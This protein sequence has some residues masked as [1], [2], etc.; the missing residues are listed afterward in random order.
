MSTAHGHMRK[1]SP[2]CM[3]NGTL[4]ALPGLCQFPRVCSLAC[5]ALPD[6][7]A[8]NPQLVSLDV[9]GNA[10][11]GLPGA[12]AG[13]GSSL[14]ALPLAYCDVS[15]NR[16]QARLRPGARWGHSD[17]LLYCWKKDFASKRAHRPWQA[18]GTPQYPMPQC[19][20]CN[21]HDASWRAL[22]PWRP[23]RMC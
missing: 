13:A 21:V 19:Y 6:V 5:R 9:H 23:Q 10:L 8:G 2:A 7:L 11:S 16:I 18:V 20:L 17:M 12:W 15:M 3:C 1:P 22:V 14:A 4:R